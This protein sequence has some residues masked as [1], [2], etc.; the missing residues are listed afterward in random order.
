M[1]YN[2]RTIVIDNWRLLY[3]HKPIH[4]KNKLIKRLA[5]SLSAFALLFALVLGV[6]IYIVTRPHPIDPNAVAMARIDLHQDIGQ[7]DADHI[8]SWLDAQPGINHVVVNTRSE[9]VL[10]TFLPA[11]VSV[12][13][14]VKKFQADLPYKNATRFKPTMAQLSGGCPAGYGSHSSL[15][16][17]IISLFK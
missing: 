5:I 8:V 2:Y 9:M 16:A 6:H 15:S 17:R 3:H 1:F 13:D 10:F 4:M 11:Q 7:D 14:L 12:G